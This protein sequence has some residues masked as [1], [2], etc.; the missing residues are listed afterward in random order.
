MSY[1]NDAWINEGITTSYLMIYF[2]E[3]QPVCFNVGAEAKL[4]AQGQS[5][6]LMT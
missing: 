5:L 2:F 6:S 1:G 3:L 4:T